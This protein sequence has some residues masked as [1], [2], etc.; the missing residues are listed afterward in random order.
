[1]KLVKQLCPFANTSILKAYQTVRRFCFILRVSVGQSQLY[2]VIWDKRV[3]PCPSTPTLVTFF[4]VSNLN[5]NVKQS[6]NKA[7]PPPLLPPLLCHDIEFSVLTLLPALFWSLIAYSDSHTLLS[8]YDANMQCR[9]LFCSACNHWLM[10][11]IRK[12]FNACC[13]HN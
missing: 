13:P 2:K 11:E 8:I 3:I 4:K 9:F 12:M 1:M 7:P 6:T 10:M 5:E